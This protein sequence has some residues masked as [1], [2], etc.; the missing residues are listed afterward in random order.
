MNTDR[1]PSGSLFQRGP[2]GL[3]SESGERSNV[4]SANGL[5][6]RLF[7]KKDEMAQQASSQLDELFS[8][9]DH[10]GRQRRLG[11]RASDAASMALRAFK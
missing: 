4:E 2:E 3:L 10:Y 11:V 9:K 8:T 5:L 6:E 7:D 1:D